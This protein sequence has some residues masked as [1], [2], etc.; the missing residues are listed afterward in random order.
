MI[1]LSVIPPDY[2]E[3][4]VLDRG[5]LTVFYGLHDSVVPPLH[6]VAMIPRVKKTHTSIYACVRA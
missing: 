4:A 5:H 3:V 2:G 1:E 6:T